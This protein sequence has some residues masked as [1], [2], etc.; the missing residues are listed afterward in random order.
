MLQRKISN[1]LL[2]VVKITG[3][4]LGPGDVKGG[5]VGMENPRMQMGWL[6]ML[7]SFYAHS[8]IRNNNIWG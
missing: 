1:F 2:G 6:R 8:L 7:H 4:M 3:E 5:T